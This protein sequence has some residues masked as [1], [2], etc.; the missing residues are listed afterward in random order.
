MTRNTPALQRLLHFALQGPS[1]GDT[2]IVIANLFFRLSFG[3][4]AHQYLVTESV[5]KQ[6]IK[7]FGNQDVAIR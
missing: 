1:L 6:L 5:L 4:E 3:Q 7:F 2:K